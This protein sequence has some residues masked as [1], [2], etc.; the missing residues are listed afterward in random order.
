MKEHYFLKSL[1]IHFSNIKGALFNQTV[2]FSLTEE[3]LNRFNELKKNSNDGEVYFFNQDISVIP[4]FWNGDNY[5]LVNYLEDNSWHLDK[6]VVIP[7]NSVIERIDSD[8]F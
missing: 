3:E 6:S 5:L 7:F 1:A 8:V 2:L 4:Y